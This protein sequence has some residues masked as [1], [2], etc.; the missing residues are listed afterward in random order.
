MIQVG[1][2]VIVYDETTHV[3]HR[4]DPTSQAV[5]GACDGTRPLPDLA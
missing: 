2:E 3:I 5:W 1:D 4:L